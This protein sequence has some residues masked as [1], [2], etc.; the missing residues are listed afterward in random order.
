MKKECLTCKH[1]DRV[2]FSEPT[3][4]YF[5]HC[6]AMTRGELPLVVVKGGALPLTSDDFGCVLHEERKA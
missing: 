1:W 4:H 3:N 5:R 2:D 6:A